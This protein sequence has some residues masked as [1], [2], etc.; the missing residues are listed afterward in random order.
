MARTVLL[1]ADSLGL[2]GKTKALADLALGLDPTRYRAEVCYLDEEVSPLPAQLTA[3]GVGLHRVPVPRGLNPRALVGFVRLLRQLRPAVVHCYNPR[4]MLYAGTAA[5]LLGIRAVLGSLSA[6]ACQVPDR[7]Y[8]FLPQKLHTLSGQNRMRNQFLARVVGAFAVV[9]RLL[10]ERFCRYNRIPLEKLRVV[11]YG[12]P[13]DEMPADARRSLVSAGR[14]QLGAAGDEIIVASVGRLVEQKDYPTQLRGFAL[15][16]AEDRRL[17]MV[18]VGAG[19]LRAELE[20]LADELGIAGRVTFLG[21]RSDVPQLLPAF[22]I[23]VMTSKFEPYGV[24]LLEAKAAGLAIVATEVNEIPEI[25]PDGR[26]GL[27]FPAGDA[28]AL[29]GRLVALAAAPDLRSRLAE[30]ALLEAR[31]K[32]S[33]RA[34]IDRYQALY[35]DLIPSNS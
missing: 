4:P 30:N 29:A 25:I 33:L 12:V 21:H 32:H 15:A 26:C 3:A 20:R 1:I 8:S 31:E 17:R 2:S 5:R 7:E 19:P 23:F 10:G 24:A 18:L 16:A 34:M 9:S 6:F 13:L 27:L 28:T 22:D 14:R 11:P 35:D